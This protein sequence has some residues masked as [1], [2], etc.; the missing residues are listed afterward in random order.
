MSDK[1]IRASEI[2]D[3]LYCHRSWWLK[4][5]LGQKSGN[6]RALTKG[7]R[8]HEQHGR[9]LSQSIWA[10]RMAYILLFCLVTILTFQLLTS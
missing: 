4:R 5:G 1:W 3:Y 9:L 2:S 8:H 10:K 7:T 6:V